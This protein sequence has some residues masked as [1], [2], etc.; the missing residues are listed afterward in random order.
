DWAG[1]SGVGASGG[2]NYPLVVSVDDT[3]EGFAMTTETHAS[4]DPGQVCA[5]MVEVL[6]GLAGEESL[7]AVDVLPA[8]ERRRVVEEFNATGLRVESGTVH[9][10]FETQVRVTPDAVAVDDGGRLLT[11]A[12]LDAA[13]DVVAA[14]LRAVG[15][16]RGSR[17]AVCA[18]RS[19][20]LVAGLLGV[21][22]AGGAYLPLDPAYPAARLEFMLTDAAPAA[23]LTFGAGI[24]TSVPVL[25]LAG[26][27]AA[28][29]V[30]EASL[31]VSGNDAAYV[32]YTSGSAGRPKGVV[33]EH[34]GVVNLLAWG[35]EVFDKATLARTLFATSV[36]FDP[37]VL[38]M[39]LPLSIGGTVVVVR[40]ALALQ[41]SPVEV[42]LID[43]AP[44]ALRA[45][46]GS[47]PAT[48]RRVN[49]GGEPL[50]ADLIERVFADSDVEEI[51]N[52]WGL[53]ET[54][55]NSTSAVIRRDFAGEVTIGRP[56]ANTK[57]Y[58]L[59]R[60]G[61]PVPVG[62]IGEIYVGGAGVAR[63]YLDRAGLTAGRYVADPLAADGSRM[64]RSGDLARWTA[65]GDLEFAGRNDFQVKIR[66]F[67]VELGEIEQWLGRHPLVVQAVVV[68]KYDRLVAY[69]VPAGEVDVADLRE[70]LAA[71]LP[72]YMVPAAFVA[73]DMLPLTANGKVD[74]KALPAPDGD[75]F[76]RAGYQEPEGEIEQAIAAVWAELL[77]VER[78]GRFDDFFVL[79]GHSL[80]AVSLV[81]RLREREI[82][83]DVRT[84]FAHPTVAA[85]AEATVTTLA[86]AVDVP[87]NLISEGT[88]VITPELLPLVEL[89]QEQI[90][91]VVAQI[92]GGVR[93]VQDI[94]ALAPLQE[95]M[96]FHHL[97]APD[98]DAY[99]LSQLLTVDSREWLDAFLDA[100]GTVVGRHEV[101]RTSFHW[102]G[103]PRPVQVVHRHA[104]LVVEEVEAG[105]LADAAKRIDLT[106]APVLRVFTAP[107]LAGWQV[108][109]VMH[110][111]V[112][113]NTSLQA[114][115]G[116]VGAVL[117]GQGDLLPVPVPYRNVVAQAVLGVSGAEH[118]EFFTG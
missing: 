20:E 25:D 29:A 104:G 106:R 38:Q 27:F 53:T 98:N 88:A 107:G 72:G 21:L 7:S 33:V 70:H 26:V 97:M 51:R 112:G 79:G 39:F 23:V 62:V 96:L 61:R 66:G 92:P 86:D 19:A 103:L 84:V 94:Y 110:H 55:V 11:Y 75:A 46:T 31:D 57:I 64:Y 5:L 1:I 13:A 54:T 45:V 10:L 42:S 71:V 82:A 3:G 22:K 116:E 83:T 34:G 108:L 17:V 37:S 18:E 69:Y 58:I 91:R 65:D 74:R 15:V 109:V 48:T 118:E 73:L 47:L 24:A 9:G 85:L 35:A 111:I 60:A 90:D 115:V 117:A 6:A 81:E 67:R 12:Q 4:I 114:I 56:I 101:L 49:V 99:V 89:S 68:A 76:A 50:G 41:E 36:S 30:S 8:S 80:L 113:D 87:V 59:D 28:T 78:V 44:S 16:V 77:G 102:E 105:K 95:G 32:I 14:R 40:D 93:N 2:T 52:L 63:G 43:T 100:L